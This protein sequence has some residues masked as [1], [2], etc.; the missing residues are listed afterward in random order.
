VAFEDLDGS[1]PSLSAYHVLANR[2]A[3]GHTLGVASKARVLIVDDEE[4]SRT[5]LTQLLSSWG[6]ETLS[7]LDGKDALE[8]AGAFRPGVIITDLIM[9]G[10]DGLELLRSVQ[11]EL[12]AVSVIVLTGHATIETA[13]SA[14]KEGAYD[15]VTKPIDLTRL[16]VLLE[17]AVEKAEAVREVTLLRR[18]LRQSRG[19]DSLVGSSPPMREVVQQIELAAPTSA[20][21]LIVGESGTGKELVARTIHERSP[22][23][24]GPFVAV[25]CSAVPDSLLESELFG[26]EKGA[27]TGAIDRRVGYF[28]LADRGTILLDEIAEMSPALQAKYLRILQDGVFRRI[29]G[30]AE[31]RV[32]VRVLAATNKD[33]LKMIQEGRFREDLY[34]RLNVFTIAVPALRQRKEDIPALVEAFIAE[35]NARYGRQVK[36]VDDAALRALNRHSWPGNVRE[37]RNAVERAVVACDGDVIRAS[38]LPFGPPVA[39]ASERPD[40]VVVPVG[41]TVEQ[42]E[43]ELILR[44][45]ESAGR[46]KTRAAEILGISLKTL[47]N[48]LNRYTF[49][50]NEPQ[51][52]PDR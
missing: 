15:Y 10:L 39:A 31:V 1:R 3:L 28:E 8:R 43:R 16:R 50:G 33:P 38:L 44:T 35:F 32:D 37:L 52:H 19:F 49:G 17:K 24:R 18:E 34:Y 42:A 29:G 36:T 30:T 46:N 4:S 9:P 45:F 41:T 21:V 26:H 6:Y 25:N 22:R 23:G 5:G 40:A 11:K 13:V 20:P 12:P 48:K 7:A 2:A 14:M 27:F 47:H 51:A